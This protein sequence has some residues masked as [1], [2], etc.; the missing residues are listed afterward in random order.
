MTDFSK[1]KYKLYWLF[2][3]LELNTKIEGFTFSL[4]K[5]LIA[6]LILQRVLSLKQKEKVINSKLHKLLVA[7]VKLHVRVFGTTDIP[8]TSKDYL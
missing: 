4:L 5:T 7:T 3:H 8:V 2:Y 1:K 6:V